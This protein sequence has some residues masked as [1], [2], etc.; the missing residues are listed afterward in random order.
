MRR[1]ILGVAGLVIITFALTLISWTPIYRNVAPIPIT[2][3]LEKEEIKDLYDTIGL[4]QSG[5]S[6][7]VFEKAVTGFYNLKN[8]GK[9]SE[10]KSIL[11]IA[12]FDQSSTKK[13]LWIIDLNKDELLLN[14]WVAHGELSGGDKA[15]Y[16]S[17][18]S[19]SLKSSIG[20]YVTG[21]TYYGKHGL[22]LK[23]DGMD[24][25]FNSNAR[26]RSI[27][28]H[29]ASYVSQGTINALGRLGRSQGCPAVPQELASTVVSTMQD[30]TALFINI[31]T[32]NYSSIYLETN[33]DRVLA[34]N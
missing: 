9:L 18:T 11:S 23:L 22:S 19:E 14:T 16:F 10:S 26:K 7:F 21:E 27:V 2:I 8:A 29:G 34:S 33:T 1:S 17:N 28:I 3:S 15:T 20:F 5:L 32:Q 6:L 30:K 31:T 12:D 4:A 13:R 25:G 24:E